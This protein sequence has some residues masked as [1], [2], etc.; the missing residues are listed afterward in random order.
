MDTL[1]AIRTRRS[2]RQI[3]PEPFEEDK[4]NQILEAG[5]WAPSWANTQSWHFIV[6]R[7]KT[8]KEQ[9]QATRFGRPPGPPPA[10]AT[11]P[12]PTPPAAQP[13]IDAPVVIAVC[14]EINKAGV[15]PDG[16]PSTDK[17]ATWYMF[18]TALAVQNMSLAAH[19]LGL[20]SVI[21]GAFDAKKAGEILKVPQG[22]AVVV[23]LPIGIPAAEGRP[24][25]RKELSEFV[26]RDEF[27]RK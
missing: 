15:R 17:G 8:I 24:T 25:P 1:E 11:P 5:R 2:I 27:G 21:I 18:D 13:L 6:V 10:G 14:G 26:Y 19:A 20:G 12:A 4:L 23:L 7:D 9:L 22:Y 3:K 16:T